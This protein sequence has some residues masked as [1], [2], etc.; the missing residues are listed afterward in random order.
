MKS[1]W[2]GDSY[3]IVKR[4]FVGILKE[5][6]YQVVVD[7][8]L[9]D[10]WNGLEKKFYDFLGAAPTSGSNSRKS[11]LLLDPDTGIGKE[12]TKQ[13]T[14]IEIIASHL[15]KYEV[16]FTF[17]QSFSR[18]DSKSGKMEKQMIEKLDLLKKTG[19]FGFYYNSHAKFL[20]AA[21]SKERLN[22]VE[23]KLRSSGLPKSRLLKI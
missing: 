21:S 12:E 13:H 1:Q 14:T 18:A 10:E 22:T 19:N 20:F 4:Y 11:A 16:V 5:V 7:P 15:Q 17:D 2:F 8:M 23:Q 3:D 6:G 9:T